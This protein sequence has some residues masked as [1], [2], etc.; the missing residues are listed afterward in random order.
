MPGV[1]EAPPRVAVQEV[2]MNSIQITF[3]LP[4]DLAAA[5]D[6]TAAQMQRNRSELVREALREFIGRHSEP[7][8]SAAEPVRDLLGSLD[9]GIPNLAENHRAYLLDF[10]K[11]DR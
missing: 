11:R 9:S 7:E 6:R 4:K 3:R 5:L 10:L 8:T 2:V 1:S